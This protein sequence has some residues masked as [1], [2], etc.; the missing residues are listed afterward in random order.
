[1]ANF[2]RKIADPSPRH[3]SDKSNRLKDKEHGCIAKFYNSRVCN[4]GKLIHGTRMHA[5]RVFF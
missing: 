1:M 5:M 3:A 4:C 2:A